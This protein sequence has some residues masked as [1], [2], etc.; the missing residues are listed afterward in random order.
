ML[1]TFLAL[2]IALG[3]THTVAAQESDRDQENQAAIPRAESF[4]IPDEELQRVAEEMGLYEKY[5]AE[6]YKKIV[7]ENQD[8]V[9]M[10]EDLRD[11]A[12]DVQQTELEKKRTEYQILLGQDPRK[13]LLIAVST[14]MPDALIKAYAKEA[15]WYGGRLVVRG[16]PK[17]MG[18]VDWVESYGRELVESKTPVAS[19]EI[20]PGLFD[21]YDIDVVPTIIWDESSEDSERCDGLPDEEPYTRLAKGNEGYVDIQ[22]CLPKSEDSYYKVSGGVTIDWALNEFS[23]AGASHAKERLNSGRRYLKQG[24]AKEQTPYD[25]DWKSEVTPETVR[26]I[27]EAFEPISPTG[28]EEHPYFEFVE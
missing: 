11:Q 19:I 7:E 10:I 27:E 22:A 5:G 15:M 21:T 1:R 3:A 2:S 9:D 14:S 8:V 28:Q 4:R 25:G 26:M 24:G 12:K 20:N 6:S 18:L 23:L 13:H 17:E 16:I